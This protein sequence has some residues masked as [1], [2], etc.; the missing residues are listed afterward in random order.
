MSYCIKILTSNGLEKE[1]M[2]SMLDY[3][4][5]NYFPDIQRLE[6][7][8]GYLREDCWLEMYYEIA[9]RTASLVA[10][11]QCYGFCHGVAKILLVFQRTYLGAK[12]R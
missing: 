11:W 4:L 12:H 9:R 8:K 7:E 2:P 5:V 3:L 6:K 10:L 1:M